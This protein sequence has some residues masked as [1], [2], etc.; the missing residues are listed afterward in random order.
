MKSLKRLPLV[1]CFLFL[2]CEDIIEC[3]FNKAPEIPDKSFANGYAYHYY[4]DEFT[5]EIKNEPEDNNYDYYYDFS[6]DL[7]EGL[8]VY[9]DYRT[10][11]IEGTPLVQG[12]F[13][14][15]VYLVVDP[16]EYYDEDSGEYEDSLCSDSTSRDFSITIN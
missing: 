12:T 7:P 10:F 1:F 13:N 2:G 5:S 14:F 11:I 3:I 16:P 15:T 9:T 6:G 4:S 8:E